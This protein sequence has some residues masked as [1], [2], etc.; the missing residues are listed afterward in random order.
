[1]PYVKR[2]AEGEKIHEMRSKQ[3]G[4]SG[5][6]SIV[7]GTWVWF[8]TLKG[9][10]PGCTHNMILGGAKFIKEHGPLV[11]GTSNGEAWWQT[12]RHTVPGT[13]QEVLL[14]VQYYK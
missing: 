1:M 7:P 3:I 14:K 10:W 8:A 4:K 5:G 13:M 12:L 11:P 2:L 9:Q 6:G